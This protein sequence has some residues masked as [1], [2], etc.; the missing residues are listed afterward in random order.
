MAADG[1]KTDSALLDLYFERSE[2]AIEATM[3]KYG[4]LLRTLSWN[5]QGNQED[6]EE[7]LND[8]YLAAWNAIPPERPHYFK[9]YLCKVARNFSL[10]KVRA[11]TRE[12]RGG[13]QIPLLLDE[14][15]ESLASGSDGA[16]TAEV[17]ELGRMISG[18]LEKQPD[19]RRIIFLKRYYF[20]S[21]I[22]EIAHEQRTTEGAVKVLLHRMRQEL[23]MELIERGYSD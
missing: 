6:V 3:A 21:S 22:K 9:A 5:I 13:G 14:A 17:R 4:G 10:D 12:K 15:E 2:E 18:Y 11:K 20:A 1:D 19:R 7:C 23:K 8:T 16:R